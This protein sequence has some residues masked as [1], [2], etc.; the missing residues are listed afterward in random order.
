M[1]AISWLPLSGVAQTCKSAIKATAPDIRYTDNGNGTVTDNQTGLM[2]KQ[3]SEG[4]SGIDCAT[5]SAT[6]YY[7]WQ[8]ALQT[9]QTL[10]LSGGMQVTPTGDCQISRN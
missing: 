2:W 6:T 1:L 8:A 7:T 10:N 3:C 5:E 4:Q 9:P